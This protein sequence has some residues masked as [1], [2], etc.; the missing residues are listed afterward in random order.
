MKLEDAEKIYDFTASS[1]G[2]E[3]RE[4]GNWHKPINVN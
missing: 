4:D 3:L 2:F 1:M